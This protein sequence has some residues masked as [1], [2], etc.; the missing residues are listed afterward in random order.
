[1]VALTGINQKERNFTCAL[2]SFRQA[3]SNELFTLHFG[4]WILS[5]KSVA[6]PSFPERKR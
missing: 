5:R 1:M 3:E 2:G 4:I 6:P